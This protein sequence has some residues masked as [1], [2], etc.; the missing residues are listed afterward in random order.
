M[1]SIDPGKVLDPAWAD[2]G[3]SE[4]KYVRR[5]QALAAPNA[6]E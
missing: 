4:P 1:A 6:A 5:A 3:L 2:K